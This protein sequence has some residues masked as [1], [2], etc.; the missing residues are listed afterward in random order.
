MLIAVATI[1]TGVIVFSFTFVYANISE[2]MNNNIIV[3]ISDI[4]TPLN[5]FLCFPFYIPPLIFMFSFYIYI[6]IKEEIELLVFYFFYNILLINCKLRVEMQ[7][8][9]HLS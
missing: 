9:R 1:I 6:D 4:P 2:N 5:I 8:R 7:T 3:N